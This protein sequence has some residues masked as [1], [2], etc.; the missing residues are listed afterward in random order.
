[1][2]GFISTYS[3]ILQRKQL[4]PSIHLNVPNAATAAPSSSNVS[5]RQSQPI[6]SIEARGHSQWEAV[7]GGAPTAAALIPLREAALGVSAALSFKQ[8]AKIRPELRRFDFQNKR[9]YRRQ[10]R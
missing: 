7:I 2:C 6:G 1:M 10:I 4:S 5:D 3:L 8:S 9:L